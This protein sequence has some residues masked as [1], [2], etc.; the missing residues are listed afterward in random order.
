ML[1]NFVFINTASHL[2]FFFISF[3]INTP[4]VY[5]FIYFAYNFV[6]DDKLIKKLLIKV[7]AFKIIHIIQR[8]FPAKKLKNPSKIN[9]NI[10]YAHILYQNILYFLCIVEMEIKVTFKPK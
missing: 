3:L 4:F 10:L 9:Q 1:S 8:L 7:F 2:T 6:R 5:L